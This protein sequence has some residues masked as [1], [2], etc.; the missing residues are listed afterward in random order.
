MR[1]E[2]RYIDLDGGVLSGPAL[3]VAEAP[4]DLCTFSD[5]AAQQVVHNGGL[6]VIQPDSKYE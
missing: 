6:D 5:S 4:L 3:Q 2:S 1:D